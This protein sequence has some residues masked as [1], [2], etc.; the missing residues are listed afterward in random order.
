M[1]SMEIHRKSFRIH[2]S[3]NL[4]WSITTMADTAASALLEKSILTQNCWWPSSTLQSKKKKI[5]GCPLPPWEE[6]DCHLPHLSH[7]LLDPLPSGMCWRLQR[8]GPLEIERPGT[9]KQVDKIVGNFLLK[10]EKRTMVKKKKEK[11]W[12]LTNRNRI[13]LQNNSWNWPGQKW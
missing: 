13:I 2:I 11:Y 10:K 4:S 12:K 7:D 8:P 5:T 3:D 6:I 1:E 9:L